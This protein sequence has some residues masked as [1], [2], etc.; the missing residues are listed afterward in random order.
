MPEFEKNESQEN[1]SAI[2]KILV[3]LHIMIILKTRELI[4]LNE[5]F[6]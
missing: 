2:K 3:K 4:I 6:H 5:I 1:L